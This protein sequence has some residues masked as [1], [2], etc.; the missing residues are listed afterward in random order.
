M[1]GA[2]ASSFAPAAAL[3]AATGAT[4]HGGPPSLRVALPDGRLCATLGLAHFNRLLDSEKRALRLY[5]HAFYLFAARPP[6]AAASASAAP[7]CSRPP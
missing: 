6:R 5:Y 2:N 3:Q 1:A 4:L 7:S